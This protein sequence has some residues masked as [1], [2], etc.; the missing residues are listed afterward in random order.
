MKKMKI[1][2]Y[3]VAIISFIIFLIGY[4]LIS[5]VNQ[6]IQI[7]EYNKNIASIKNEMLKVDEEIKKIKEDINNYKKDEYIEKIAREKLKM[8][9]PGE[10]IYIDVNKKDS[11]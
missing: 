1:N 7:N 2:I 10:I 6:S 8:A 4:T 9:K 5:F 3:G 11:L